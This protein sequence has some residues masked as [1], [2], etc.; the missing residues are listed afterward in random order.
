MNSKYVQLPTSIQNE[1][2]I[3]INYNKTSMSS[4]HNI[5][6]VLLYLPVIDFSLNR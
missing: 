5:N 6:T 3:H 1:N 2:I 4:Y